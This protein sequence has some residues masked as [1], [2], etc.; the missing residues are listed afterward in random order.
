MGH[1]LEVAR[2]GRARCRACQQG[3]A[4]GERRFGERQPNPFGDGEATYWFHL[5][6]GARKVPA[7]YLAALEELAAPN[8]AAEAHRTLAQRIAGHHRLPRLGPVSVAPTGRARCRQCR[9]LIGKGDYRIHLEVVADGLLDS[10]GFIHARCAQA[11]F[12]TEVV[13]VFEALAIDLPAEARAELQARDGTT[14]G[15]HSG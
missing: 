13:D 5:Q 10:W 1:V 3:I 6:C 9:D 12:E 15:S 14:P 4:K 8:P 11:Y 7:A 2:S